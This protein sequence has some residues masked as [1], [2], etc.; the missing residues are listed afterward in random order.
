MAKVLGVPI[1]SEK[2]KTVLPCTTITFV[3]IEVDSILMEKRLPSDKLEKI[4]KL[5]KSFQHKKKATLVELQSLIGLLN[6]AC[7]VV[8]PGRPFLRHLIDLTMGLRAPHYRRR[9]IKEARADLHA[10]SVFIPVRW[11]TPDILNLYTDS[12]N[13]GFGDYLNNEWFA[14]EWPET[15]KNFHI[16]IKEPFPI[17]LAVEMWAKYLQ[18]RCII[19]HTDNIACAYIINK[20]SSKE[21]TLMV[22]VRRLVVQSLKYNIMFK[23]EHLPGIQNNLSDKLSRQQITEFLR[24]FPHKPP[25]RVDIPEHSLVI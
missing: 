9:L 8:I 13:I 17:V 6:F 23:A 21:S 15:W 20:L 2:K 10:W 3:G 25:I 4:R 7:S 14:G 19:F 11:L 22:L 1:K 5:L 16:T 18:N 12:S 24:L